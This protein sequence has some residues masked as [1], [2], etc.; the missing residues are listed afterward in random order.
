MHESTGVRE[1]VIHEFTRASSDKGFGTYIVQ[2][3]AVISIITMKWSLAHIGIVFLAM[4]RLTYGQD[5]VLIEWGESCPEERKDDSDFEWPSIDSLE[6]YLFESGF[7]FGTVSESDRRWIVECGPKIRYVKIIWREDSTMQYLPDAGQMD[8]FQWKETEF[9]RHQVMHHLASTGYPY[10]QLMTSPRKVRKDTLVLEYDLEMLREIKI[11]EVKVSEGFDIH[12]PTFCSMIGVKENQSF[13]VEKIRRSEEIIRRW[14]FASLERIR[15][16]FQ[17]SGVNLEYLVETTDASQFDLLVALIPSSRPH[18]QYELTGNAY[19]DLQNQLNRAERIFFRFDKYANSSQSIDMRLDFP[20]LSVLRSGVVAEGRLDRRDSSVIDVV[21]RLGLR[22]SR[23]QKN[24]WTLFF[25]RDQS[26]LITIEEEWMKQSGILPEE[27]DFNYTAGGVSFENNSLD[28]RL[29][30]RKGFVGRWEVT[31]GMRKIIPNPKI[32][33]VEVDPA[34]GE[35]FETQYANRGKPAIRTSAFMSWDQFVPVGS[36][37]TIRM[38]AM[39]EWIWSSHELLDNELLRLGGFQNFRGFPEKLFLAEMY[40]LGTLE[41]RFLFGPQSNAYVFSDFGAL[42][43]PGNDV[44]IDFP[45]SAGIGLNLGTKAGVFGISYAV[46][47]R[48]KIPFSLSQSRVNFG[49]VVHY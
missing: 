16:D 9:H 27:L 32:L 42:K 45:Y 29:N 17:P 39:G 7:P 21:G 11:G 8:V 4:I 5:P 49:L 18:Q 26:R 36:Y 23:D 1:E 2:E 34:N 41:Y 46:G 25:K 30:P 40:G 3:G 33:A 15:Y 24:H 37:A 38:R 28:Y 10:A 43:H 44:S 13:D 19:I 6:N 22:Y 47:G 31:G 14:D 35:S 20:Y 48:R 12:L